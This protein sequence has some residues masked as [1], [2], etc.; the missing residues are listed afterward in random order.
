MNDE[1]HGLYLKARQ[2]YD[3]DDTNASVLPMMKDAYQKGSYMALHFLCCYRPVLTIKDRI[4]YMKQL[5]S[6]Y[7]RTLLAELS[8]ELLYHQHE[9]PPNSIVYATYHIGKMIHCLRNLPRYSKKIDG[10]V[11]QKCESKYLFM[12]ERSKV[13][14]LTWMIVAKRLGFYRDVAQLIGRLVWDGR[15]TDVYKQTTIDRFFKRSKK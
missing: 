6:V 8:F 11:L 9:W 10:D 14:T 1:G 5:M 13:A 4:E 3:S 12:V 15:M 2:L 7:P